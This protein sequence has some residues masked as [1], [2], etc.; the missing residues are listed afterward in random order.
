MKEVQKIKGLKSQLKRMQGDT[1]ALKVEISNKQKEC[2]NKVK[3]IKVLKEQIDKFENNKNIKVSEHA[4]VRYFERV[5]GFD[6]SEVER[7]ILTE[8]VLILIEKLG[9]TGGYP[10]KD[11]K[12]IIKN[13]TVTT[14][15]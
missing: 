1:E 12:V 13:Y 7:D 6:I 14:V 5:K 10:N 3:A 8:E 15:V 4:I 11:F 9:G 2:N